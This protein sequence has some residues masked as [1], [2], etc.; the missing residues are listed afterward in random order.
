MKTILLYSAVVAAL[1]GFLFGFDSGVISGCEEAIQ[2]E[3]ALSP[4]WH[5]LV[6]AGA[7]IGTVIG[8]FCASAPAD[9]WGRRPTLVGMALLF[10]VSAVGC[11]L[12]LARP[13]RGCPL[14]VRRRR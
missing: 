8:V 11:A 12:P 9:R 10:L 13:L 1:G 2:R 14:I 7:L 3:F 5:G 6:V 4:F